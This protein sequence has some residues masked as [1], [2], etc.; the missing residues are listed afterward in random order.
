M[1]RESNKNNNI[2]IRVVTSIC[3]VPKNARVLV[4]VYASLIFQTRHYKGNFFPM[5][6]IIKFTSSLNIL[7]LLDIFN[8]CWNRSSVVGD[9]NCPMKLCW[10][11]NSVVDDINCPMKQVD[12]VII[13]V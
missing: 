7:F 9:I 1:M 2:I 5:Q 11:R 3:S 12:Q 8:L 4:L 6:Q 13:K 10:N